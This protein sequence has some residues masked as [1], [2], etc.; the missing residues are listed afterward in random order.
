VTTKSEILAQFEKGLTVKQISKEFSPTS[1]YKYYR[2][3]LMILLR[4]KVQRVIDADRWES[5]SV[6]RLKVLIKEVSGWR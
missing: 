1:V 3:Y 2:L 5:L 4:D 6:P